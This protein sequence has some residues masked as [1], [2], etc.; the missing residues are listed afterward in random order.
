MKLEGAIPSVSCFYIAV[1][2][3]ADLH[4]SS[5]DV[6]YDFR[7]LAMVAALCQALEA[8]W[9]VGLHASVN[10]KQ[11]PG[12]F[13]VEKQ[14]LESQLC[15]YRVRGLRHHYWAMDSNTPE[16]T[17]WAHAAA[18]FDYDS[19]LGLNDSP[20]F[21]RGMAWPFQPFD[22]DRAER[23]PILEIPPTLM[24]GGIFS[25]KIT[26]DKGY[27]QMKQHIKRVFS[28]GGCV[29]FNWHLEQ[30]NPNRLRGAGPILA[31]VLQELS[32]D[33]NIFWTSPAQLSDWWR[34]RQRQLAA[35]LL[36]E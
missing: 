16:R 26:P 3:S 28:L 12:R 14:L 9:E 18:G 33:S 34:S 36:T 1:T 27:W 2:T 6:C 8:G 17:L 10:A 32:E 31:R 30:L 13:V 5:V 24:D 22:R 25:H 23:V 19:S 20:A 11:D 29:V 15:G 35:G 7:H 21:R 4:A